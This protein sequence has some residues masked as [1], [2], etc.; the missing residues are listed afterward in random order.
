MNPGISV[1][2]P[3]YNTAA[4]LPACLDSILTQSFRDLEVIC[5]DDGSPD[6]SGEIL[7]E[8]SGRDE[9]LTV[10]AKENAG[11]GAARNSG[12][13]VA[14][15][16][17]ILFVDSDDRLLPDALAAMAAAAAP[18]IDIVCGGHL[19]FSERRGVTL[20]HACNAADLVAP[21]IFP[22]FMHQQIHV[23][24]WAKLFRRDFLRQ[25]HIRFPETRRSFEDGR[26][27]AEAFFFAR[28]VRLID[29]LVYRWRRAER[30]TL[31]TCYSS[32][33]F[34]S[35]WVEAKADLTAF[36]RRE[37]VWQEYAA[38]PRCNQGERVW[39]GLM[40]RLIVDARGQSSHRIASALNTCREDLSDFDLDDAAAMNVIFKI[41]ADGSRR[42]LRFDKHEQAAVA[43]YVAEF[44]ATVP[45]D[46]LTT[47]ELGVIE[48]LRSVS[49]DAV[50]WRYLRK[51][52]HPFRTADPGLVERG[53]EWLDDLR[54]SLR[55][56][57]RRRS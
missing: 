18:D 27:M 24:A 22:A 41:L 49:P 20:P 7:R 2:V 45:A 57:G 34:V 32:P 5:V 3:V 21:R 4:F 29:T 31:R 17:N 25:H 56:L 14:V 48:H 16:E 35:D 46:G 10:V 1:I 36:L 42:I 19:T 6:D 12:M 37:G 55:R 26:P 50:E 15:G 53:L 51:L 47:A 13:D 30:G 43:A 40:R 52:L 54:F 33:R 44:L 38:L 39:R 9:R 8:Y 23:T 11:L 28:R